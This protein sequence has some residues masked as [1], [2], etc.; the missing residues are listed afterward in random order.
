MKPLHS[1]AQSASVLGEQTDSSYRV[2]TIHLMT[3]L[4]VSVAKD[5]ETPKYVHYNYER[6]AVRQSINC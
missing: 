3:L 4:N 6:A 2:S 5:G 1:F